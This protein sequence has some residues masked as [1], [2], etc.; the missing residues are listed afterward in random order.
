MYPVLKKV[1]CELEFENLI[2]ALLRLEREAALLI[3]FRQIAVT[4]QLCVPNS[5]IK[6]DVIIHKSLFH[7]L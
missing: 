2:E 4:R 1:S 5:R 6:L 3:R 7:K